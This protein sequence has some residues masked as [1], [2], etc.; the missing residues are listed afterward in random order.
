MVPNGDFENVSNLQKT[1]K[2]SPKSCPPID[3]QTFLLT[4]S[5]WASHVGITIGN[6]SN[7]Y[8]VCSISDCVL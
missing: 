4:S 8:H 2:V 7:A 5:S 3:V 6:I 1:D